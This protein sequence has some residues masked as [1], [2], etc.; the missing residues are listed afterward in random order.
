MPFIDNLCPNATGEV[1]L[2]CLQSLPT[3]ALLEL[4]ETNVTSWTSVVDG[5]YFEDMSIA[6]LAKGRQYVNKVKFMAGYMPN[7][8]QSLIAEA[9]PPNI[10]SLEAGLKIMQHPGAL[11]AK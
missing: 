7:E 10:T 6:Q 5:I 1:R 2:E 4:T 9:L 3:E 8:Y 11:N